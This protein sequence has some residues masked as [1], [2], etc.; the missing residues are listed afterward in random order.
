M[1]RP[2]KLALVPKAH[3]RATPTTDHTLFQLAEANPTFAK[4]H[5]QESAVSHARN[6]EDKDGDVLECRENMGT[7]EVG[8]EEKDETVESETLRLLV[9]AERNYAPDP[10]YL[11]H[12]QSEITWTMRLI[13]LDWMMEVSAEFHFT[14]ECFHY[15]ANYV[16]RY[17]SRVPDIPR[18]E[19]QLLGAAALYLAAKV[20]EISVPRIRDFR[21]V[22]ADAYETEQIRAMETSLARTL[23]W[24]LVPPTL[25][26]WAKWYMWEWDEYVQCCQSAN[27][28]VLLKSLPNPLVVFKA[29]NEKAYARFRE[30][31]QLLDLAVLSVDTLKHSPR[32]IVA[33]GMYVLLAYHFGQGT[34]EEIAKGM[35]ESDLFLDARLPFNDLFGRFLRECFGIELEELLRTIQHMARFM[36]FK[37]DRSIPVWHKVKG[38]VIAP[39]TAIE[40]ELRRVLILPNTQSGAIGVSTP[41]DEV[42]TSPPKVVYTELPIHSAHFPQLK[43]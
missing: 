23:S 36:A 6:E 33:G 40:S 4:R 13:L 17:L 37:F 12:F 42:S 29:S 26:T 18:S 9:E 24:Q 7:I 28:C 25:C 39:L 10:Y 2:S 19:L 27:S 16:D 41:Q 43:H 38:S 30:L 35:S 32:A 34:A 22:T 21:R 5:K 3:K 15:S 14:R 11:E 31:S 1:P 8:E 20:E